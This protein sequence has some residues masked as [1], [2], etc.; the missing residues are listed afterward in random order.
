MDSSKA[1]D[2]GKLWVRPSIHTAPKFALWS[3]FKNSN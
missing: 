2:D 1:G 3:F